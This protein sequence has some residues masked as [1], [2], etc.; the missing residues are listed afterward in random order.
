MF[1]LTL[2]LTLAWFMR[3]PTRV[4]NSTEPDMLPF[5]RI[6]C[7]KNGKEAA[8]GSTGTVTVWDCHM[9]GILAAK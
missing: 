9:L 1:A 2:T 6:S 4:D 7:L 8:G 5:L 3:S